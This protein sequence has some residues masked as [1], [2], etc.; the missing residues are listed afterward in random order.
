VQSTP[1]AGLSPGVW[2]WLYRTDIVDPNTSAAWTP[3]GVNSA[4]IGPIIIS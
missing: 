3:T 1:A 4:Q 2:T